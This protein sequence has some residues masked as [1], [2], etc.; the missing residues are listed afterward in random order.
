MRGLRSGDLALFADDSQIPDEKLTLETLRAPGRRIGAV[1]AIDASGSMK[2]QAF[3]SAKQAALTLL[4]QMDPSDPVA[5]L[6]FGDDVDVIADFGVERG[7]ASAAIRDRELDLARG[8]HTRL[9]DG[10]KRALELVRANPGVPRRSF[11][12]VLSDGED[13]GSQAKLDDVVQLATGVGEQAPILV[14]AIGYVGR[15]PDSATEALR[16]LAER[17]GGSFM[18]ADSA[19]RVEDF[20][21]AAASQVLS[22]YVVRFPADFDGAK[23]DIRLTLGES[24]VVRPFTYPPGS[25]SLWPMLV[26]LAVAALVVALAMALFGWWR[27]VSLGRLE[28]LSGQSQGTTFPLRPGRTRIGAN[29]DNDLMLPTD[30]VSRYHAEII[31]HGRRVE[32]E[33]L[34]SKNGTFVNGGPVDKRQRLRPGDRIRIADVE[35][36]F[37]R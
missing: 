34:R 20:F 8:Q 35:L 2:G 19:S 26:A 4:Q 21:D 28:I 15:A 6:T 23:H 9:Y 30:A 11:V 10:L 12:I 37:E 1:V 33:D 5:V 18:R 29:E 13:D 14:F 25:G 3:N 32:I 7:A 24:S 31:A 27:S 16:S 36:R 22:S 17:A